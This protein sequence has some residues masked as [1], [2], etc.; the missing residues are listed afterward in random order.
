LDVTRSTRP[1]KRARKLVLAVAVAMALSGC[2]VLHPGAAAVVGHQTISESQVDGLA[3]GLCSSFARG[4]AA[5]GGQV[6]PSREARQGALQTLVNS[7][8]V[9]QFAR[10]A[11][12]T[13]S[14]ST[15]SAQAAPFQHAI[16]TLPPSQRADFSA[17]VTGY[18][19]SQAIIYDAGSRSLESQ[20]KK[21]FSRN[22]AVAEGNRLLQ[23]YIKGV[24]VEV[25]PRFGSWVRGNLQ[26][27][28]AS[29]S[30][31][32]SQ[33]ARTAAQSSPGA[34]WIGQLPASQKCS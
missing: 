10:T 31:P 5:Q 32:V 26:P 28:A 16:S 4:A 7:E 24:N 11:G 2:G 6:P 14:N 22:Q 19:E 30:V 33:S 17:A 13:P 1:R 8:L 20:N 23:G 25:D 27:A 9:H 3:R 12:I 34:T 29:L 21:H 15:V 18:A